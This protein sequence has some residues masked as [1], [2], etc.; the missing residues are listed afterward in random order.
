MRQIFF[1]LDWIAQPAFVLLAVIAIWYF[2]QLL[3]ARSEMSATYFELERDLAS[4]RQANAIM[5]IIIII[6]VVI[7]LF[8]VQ[9]RA[10]P[11]LETEAEMDIA[12]IAEANPT[13]DVVFATRTSVADPNNNLPL[14]VGTP[15]G[16]ESDVIVLT[17][18]PTPT[19]VGTIV[20]NAPPITGCEDPRA[21]LQVP[22]NGQRV[23]SLLVVRG[24]AFTDN[25]REAKIEVS[26]PSTFGSY[27]V[28]SGGIVQS[29]E[30][31]DITQFNPARYEEG[32]YAFRLMV[33][34]I[35]DTLVASCEV[36][37]YISEPPSLATPTPPVGN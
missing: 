8:G 18:T 19:P 34:D 15:L 35:T 36:T 20:P 31:N 28:D 33:F 21:Q 37:I 17:P 10:V 7:L 2:Y 16:L 30:V 6:E 9:V 13:E 1:A 12:S 5:V 25:F 23:F 22:A 24:T 11:F 14:E 3:Q 32:A 27:I 4:R 29:R 26:G